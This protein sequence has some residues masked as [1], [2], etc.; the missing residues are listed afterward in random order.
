MLTING[1]DLSTLGFVLQNRRI[2]RMPGTQQTIVTVPGFVGGRRLGSVVAPAT[3]AAPGYVRGDTHAELLA[4]LDTIAAALR[5]ECVIRFS[6]ITDREWVGRLR[7]SALD[8]LGP[9]LVALQATLALEF[10]LEE[11]TAR[12]QAETVYSATNNALA[13][14]SAPSPIQVSL[15]AAGGPVTQVLLQ[16]RSGGT[17][18]AVVHLLQWDG[19]IPVGQTLVVD[20]STFSVS[21]NGANAVGGLSAN[22]EF[23]IADPAEVDALTVAQT[24]GSG[25]TRDIRYRKRWY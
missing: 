24:G 19:S 13:L 12:A 18:G 7:P 25:V 1:T 14:G 17:G 4:R 5:G 11:P 10:D 3:L 6:D 16:L 21:L 9:S 23:P 2:P 15:T 22:S 8:E 20:A